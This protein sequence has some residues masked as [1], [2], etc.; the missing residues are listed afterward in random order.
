MTRLGLRALPGTEM[1]PP[2][3]SVPVTV[4]VLTRNEESG[5]D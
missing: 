3:R 4:V 2:A 5:R 1:T